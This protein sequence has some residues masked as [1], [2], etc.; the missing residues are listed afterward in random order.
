MLHGKISAV[1]HADLFSCTMSKGLGGIPL[2]F[3][4]PMP[5]H[6]SNSGKKH[7]TIILQIICF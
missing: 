5:S 1:V 7:F 2:Y 4:L 3:G 6:H